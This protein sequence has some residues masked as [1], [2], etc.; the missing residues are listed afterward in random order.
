MY[1]N[2]VFFVSLYKLTIKIKIPATLNYQTVIFF[3]AHKKGPQMMRT[4]NTRVTCQVIKTKYTYVI[5]MMKNSVYATSKL[6][7][8]TPS[9]IR[10]R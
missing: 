8:D 3:M 5:T 10:T 6:V 1:I 7:V 9:G 4:K 2:G